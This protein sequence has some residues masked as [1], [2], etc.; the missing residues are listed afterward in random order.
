MVR[1]IIAGVLGAVVYFA[2]GMAAWMLFPLH[3][4]TIKRLP[5][6]QTITGAL[7]RQ[8][9]ETGVY[10]V[11]FGNPDAWNDPNSEFMQNHRAGP[12]YS[13]Y[14]QKEGSV[15]MNS[16]VMLRGFG[17]DLLATLLA[18]C[19]LSSTGG[20][21]RGYACRVGFVMGL[22]IF[23]ALVGHASYWNWMNFPIDYTLAFMADV[24]IGWAL[25]GLVMA[26][27]VRPQQE[28]KKEKNDVVAEVTRQ[29]KPEPRTQAA[30]PAR[31]DAITLLAT[32]Q[33]EARF[34]DIVKEPLADYSDEQVGAAARDVLRDCGAVLDRLFQL[35]PV[36]DQEEGT[37]VEVPTGADE[38][39][40][41]ITG[42][43]AG[44]APYCGPLVHHGWQAKRCN[45][46]QW[47]GSED[48]ALIVAP[49]ELEVKS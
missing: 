13:I 16:G 12:I 5:A 3:Q 43:V 45:L 2:W 47:N 6:E 11:P 4:P 22:G 20:C 31:N 23:V 36:V 41:R 1:I 25:V 35:Q 29:L 17:I 37:A 9:L 10:R 18:A 28:S 38:G 7:T 49:A 15:P 46:P 44:Q 39:R 21:C 14:Y 32:L 33:R 30:A 34:I 42:N 48:A 24:T 19:L 8:P 26:A 27:I 40:Y